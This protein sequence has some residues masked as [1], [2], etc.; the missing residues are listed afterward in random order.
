M[1][2][3]HSP[4]VRRSFPTLCD[5]NSPDSKQAIE[6]FMT[7]RAGG[8]LLA[9]SRGMT[10]GGTGATLA[11]I[12][13][14]AQVGV[15]KPPLLWSLQ[16]AAV[17]FPLWLALA[18]SYEIWLAF[19]LDFEE[20][21]NIKWLRRAQAVLFYVAGL[22]TACS[23]GFLLYALDPRAATI[24]VISCLVG[25]VVVA[26]TMVGAGYRLASHLLRTQRREP[27]RT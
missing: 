19:K 14:L 21:W 18:L 10:F 4:H 16:I 12:L 27:P 1:R 9:S 23:I 17:A 15:G 7:G 20:L 2:F 5:M 25:I 8:E 11:L 22:L 3:A 6:K 24:F 13:L 26:A